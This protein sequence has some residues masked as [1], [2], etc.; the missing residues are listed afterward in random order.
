MT[1]PGGLL[2]GVDITAEF[3]TLDKGFGEPP[4]TKPEPDK[5]EKP[6]KKGKGGKGAAAGKKDPDQKDDSKG[7]DP[8]ILVAE[9]SLSKSQKVAKTLIKESS[10]ARYV[11]KQLEALGIYSDLAKNLIET[12]A[13]MET[14]YHDLQAYITAGVDRRESYTHIRWSSIVGGAT[15][16]HRDKAML[17]SII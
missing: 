5:K 15:V 4:A 10:D 3:A 11:G 8:P 6:D 12:S 16:P 1:R 9:T 17:D 13:I 7:A 2:A 14:M